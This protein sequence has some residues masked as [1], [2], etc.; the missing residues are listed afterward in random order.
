[1]LIE[2]K[3]KGVEKGR[4]L[5]VEVENRNDLGVIPRENLSSISS[6]RISSLLSPLRA[7]SLVGFVKETVWFFKRPRIMVVVRYKSK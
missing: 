6:R 4:F 7:F 1:M 3:E 5:V 2:I